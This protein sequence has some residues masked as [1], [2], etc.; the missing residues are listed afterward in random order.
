MMDKSMIMHLKGQ[1]PA[2]SRIKIWVGV[3][4]LDTNPGV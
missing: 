4:I 1:G 2:S 3:V